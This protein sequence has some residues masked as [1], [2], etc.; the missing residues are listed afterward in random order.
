MLEQPSMA[1]EEPN[2]IN[3]KD[4][5]YLQLNILKTEHL[6]DGISEKEL[7]SYINLKKDSE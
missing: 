2:L 5:P 6:L 3:M 7:F 4:K 1:S